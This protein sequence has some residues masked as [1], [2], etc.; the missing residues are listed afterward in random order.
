[1]AELLTFEDIARYPRPGMDIPR[2]VEFILGGRQIAYLR[3]RP[4]TLVQDL[5]IHDIASGTQRQV[6]APVDEGAGA[7][8]EFTLDEELRRER[9]RIREQGITAYQY[10]DRK[11]AESVLL[12]P[13]NGRLYLAIGDGP[14]TPLA[15]TDGAIEAR[16]NPAGSHVAFVRE[17]EIYVVSTTGDGTPRRLTSGAGQA[18]TNGVAEYIAEEEMGRHEGYW[19]SPDGARLAFIQADSAPIPLYSITHQG[20][21][22]FFV[23]EYRYPFAGGP[24]ARVRLGVTSVDGRPEDVAWMDLGTDEDIYLARVAWRTAAALTATI[25]PRDQRS[26]DLVEFDPTTGLGTTLIE[27]QG[28]PWINLHDATR[29]LESGEI[30]WASEKTGFRHF[31]LHASDGRELRALTT[32]EWMVTGV[33]AVDEAKRVVYFIGTGDGAMERH[34]Y[35]VSL[36]DGEP[37]RLTEEAGW[38]EAVISPDFR[39]WVDTWSSSQQAPRLTLRRLDDGAVETVLFENTGMTPDALGLVVPEFIS[40]TNSTGVLL[41]AAVYASETTRTGG[42]PRPLIVSVYGGPHAQMVTDSWALTMDLRAQYLAQQGFVVLKVDNQGSANR[43]LAFEAPLAANMGHVEVQDQMEG[44][45]FLA[46]RPYV[47]S[48]RVAVYGWSYGGYMTLRLLLLAPD[49]FKAGVAGAP[50]TVWEGYDSHYTERYMGSP[51]ANAAAY[52]ASSVLA[53]A[54]ELRG[55]L[56]LIHGMV[57]ENVHFRHTSR[58]ITALTQADKSY[59]AVLFPE[60]RHMPR[61]HEDLV[62][63]ERRLVEFLRTH[64][65]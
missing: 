63:L 61:R 35:A 49:I 56:L 30:L 28:E 41:H 22:S 10:V 51:V 4:A 12:V 45:R 58:L 24:N 48:E 11:D 29:F 46:E 5:W 32:G 15:G 34:L 20:T 39:Y 33:A 38:Y 54:R 16:L 36:E 7:A 19:W 47:D 13:L 31:Y 64:M 23:E 53:H 43:G 59:E 37:R 21:D 14:L 52:Q 1:M 55:H 60:E 9:R 3:S 2:Q 6:T 50:V 25:E 8:A 17:G 42:T 26:V 18:V 57:D 44:V 40:F 27:E 65:E 62:Y